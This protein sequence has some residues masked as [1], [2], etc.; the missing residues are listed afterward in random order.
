M[1][2]EGR[3]GLVA[4]LG[5]QDVRPVRLLTVGPEHLCPLE[6][7]RVEQQIY[8]HVPERL[9]R[10]DGDL[11]DHPPDANPLRKRHEPVERGDDRIARMH[12]R[13][14]NTAGSAIRNRHE[15]RG[16]LPA[17]RLRRLGAISL[18]SIARL[19]WSVLALDR[20]L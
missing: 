11:D 20:I 4:L 10:L 6:G 8:R 19:W 5:R 14:T 3:S 2:Q 9:R 12:Q 17:I 7:R 15:L 13:E 16:L 18:S 1:C